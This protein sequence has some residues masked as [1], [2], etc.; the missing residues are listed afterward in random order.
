[1]ALAPADFYAYSRA[2]GAPYPEDPEERAQMAPAVAEFR[3][4]QLKAPQQESNPLAAIG[5]AALGLGGLAGLGFGARRLL[6]APQEVRQAGRKLTDLP[7]AEAAIKTAARYKPVDTT[8]PPSKTAIPQSTVD[9]STF[10][11]DAE[12]LKRLELEEAEAYSQIPEAQQEERRATRFVQGIESKEKALAKNVL[13][14]LRRESEAAAIPQATVDLTPEPVRE[15]PT[16]VTQ[17]GP[18]TV[19]PTR[20]VQP[21]SFSD[22]TSIQDSLL[23]QARN[24]AVNAVE[25]GEDQ[26][27]QRVRH[28][29]QSLTR[30]AKTETSPALQ[31]LYNAGLE[32]F[33]INARI[34]AF[35]QYGKPEFLDL[36]Y[37]TATVGPENFARTLE[38]DAPQFDQ[39]GRLIGGRYAA[40]EQTVQLPGEQSTVLPEG[41]IKRSAFATQQPRP[42]R[43]RSQNDEE[44]WEPISEALTGLTGG[45]S[46]SAPPIMQ[47]EQYEQAINNFSSHWNNEVQ[48]HLSGE[49]TGITRP[50]R[51]NRLVDSFDLDLPVRIRN[52]ESVNKTGDVVLK[53]EE[54]LY[55]DIL[56]SEVVSQIERGEQTTLDVP[57]LVDKNRAI[58]V[59]ELNPTTENRVDAEH[60]RRTGRALVLAH[61]KIVGPY[62]NEQFIPDVREG[63]YYQRLENL[64]GVPDVTPE[65]GRGSQKGRLV[66]GTAEPPMREVI[67]PLFYGAHTTAA[68][69]TMLIN[70]ANIVDNAGNAMDLGVTTLKQLNELGPAK[71]FT[72]AELYVS[73]GQQ[74]EHITTQPMAVKRPLRDAKPVGKITRKGKY[75][76]FTNDVYEAGETIV[77]APLQVLDVK[78]GKQVGSAAQIKRSDLA[79]FLNS[80][81]APGMDYTELGALANQQLAAQRGITLPVLESPTAFEFIESVT[82]RPGSRQS[83]KSFVTV[84]AKTGDV[85]PLSK[86]D[87]QALGFAGGSVIDPQQGRKYVGAPSL[88]IREAPTNEESWARIGEG[89]EDWEQLS[90]FA[91]ESLGVA[92]MGGLQPRRPGELQQRMTRATTGAGAEMERVRQQL[93]TIKPNE[94]VFSNEPLASNLE[95]VTQQLMAQAGRRAGKRRNR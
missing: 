74:L 50:P 26:V 48:R 72:G 93:A 65:F 17:I 47:S 32:D 1:M 53:K 57:F 90:N 91:D 87:A 10:T 77:Q 43:T 92:S 85:Y 59:A 78:T 37:N 81:R 89:A 58:A 88:D 19:L 86:E 61:E 28:R 63:S 67:Y 94:V 12:F 9:L 51:R 49:S 13:L 5:A 7:S 34:N 75:G 64:G 2:T 79:G 71:D 15:A 44:K 16:P 36:E 24:Q 83:R 22:L 6:R 14:D 33:E 54:I 56:P 42:V 39:S 62:A 70:K 69:K 27:T 11:N 35:A 20:A 82:G 55:R 25:S 41:E 3:R 40:G 68:G 95:V 18:H 52:V 46:V 84:N 4:N 8:P 38:V 66:G 60:Y 29:T 73:P 45:V 80:L 76:D 31:K 30:S 21:G 23:N